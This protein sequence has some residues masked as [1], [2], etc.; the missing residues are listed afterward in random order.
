M[1]AATLDYNRALLEQNRL[2]TELIDQADWTAPVPTCPGWSVQQLFRHVGRGDRWAAQIITDQAGAD[3]DPRS[4]TD[5]KPPEDSA[6][7]VAWL[8]ASPQLVINA[9]A[10]AGP[11]APAATFLGPRPAAW[12]VRRRLHE[13]TVHRFD[14][15][16]ALGADYDL[17]SELAADGITEWLDLVAARGAGAL[18]ADQTLSLRATD[19]GPGERDAWTMRGTDVDVTPEPDGSQTVVSGAATDLFLALVRRRSTDEAAL[20]VSGDAMTW[21]SWLAATPF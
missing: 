15:A 8:A 19:L 18:P 21:S 5:G 2:F 14:A 12:W 7:A 16:L 4:V 17:S 20:T 13:A 11:D 9:V 1:P 6:G 3:L 10:E